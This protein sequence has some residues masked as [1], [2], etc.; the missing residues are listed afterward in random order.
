VVKYERAEHRAVPRE[1]THRCGESSSRLPSFRTGPH[2]RGCS[3][4]PE[5]NSQ[6]IPGQRGA[7]GSLES[8]K[9]SRGGVDSVKPVENSGSGMIAAEVD[10]SDWDCAEPVEDPG[11]G[12]IGMQV[13]AS[14]R[15]W[16]SI[17]SVSYGGGRK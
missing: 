6:P 14:D 16:A 7:P 17:E 15:D 1:P 2:W 3:N 13:D 12:M 11:S 10:A 4:C 5:G 8:K 9:L